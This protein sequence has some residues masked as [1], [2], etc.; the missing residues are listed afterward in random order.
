MSPVYVMWHVSR[1]SSL[2]KKKNL[3]RHQL[4]A[5]GAR[6]KVLHGE[7]Q[8]KVGDLKKLRFL[9]VVLPPQGFKKTALPHHHQVD[10]GCTSLPAMATAALARPGTAVH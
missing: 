3:P 8:L 7:I 2:C 4:D 5:A 6:G 10:Q 1:R 9:A